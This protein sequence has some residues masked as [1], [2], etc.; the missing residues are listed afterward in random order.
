MDRKKD[1]QKEKNVGMDRQKEKRQT[2]KKRQIARKQA[3]KE[4]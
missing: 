2:E 1:G 4:D 3:R